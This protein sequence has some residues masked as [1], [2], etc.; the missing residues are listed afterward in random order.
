MQPG[1]ML[2]YESASLIHG[3]N[4][5][6]FCFISCDAISWALNQHTV[7]FRLAYFPQRPFP[8]KGNFYANVFIHF[9]PTGRRLKDVDAEDMKYNTEH[10]PGTYEDDVLLPPYLMPGSPEAYNYIEENPEGWNPDVFTDD[11]D[12]EDAESEFEGT[13]GEDESTEG[14]DVGTEDEGTVNHGSNDEL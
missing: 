8:L 13:E 1:D 10:N 5:A 6:L 7:V 11:S 12:S 3:V 9:E 4:I 14:E 2:L